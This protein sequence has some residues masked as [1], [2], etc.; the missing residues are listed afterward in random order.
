[1]AEEVAAAGSRPAADRARGRRNS[2]AVA[3]TAAEGAAEGAAAEEAE[4][5]E[6]EAAVPR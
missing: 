2:M 5:E 1:V 4:T 6:E 3:Q